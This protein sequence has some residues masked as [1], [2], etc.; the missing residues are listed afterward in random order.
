MK[1]TRRGTVSFA[2]ASAVALATASAVA[3]ATAASSGCARTPVDSSWLFVVASDTVTVEEAAAHWDSFSPGELR[4]FED[5]QDL[6]RDFVDAYSGM[7]LVRY[8]LAR[9]GF[10][11]TPEFAMQREGTARIRM[12]NALQDSVLSSR[13]RSVSDE[14]IASFLADSGDFFGLTDSST[15]HASAR[16]RIGQSHAFAELDSLLTTIRE[17][18]PAEFRPP[19]IARFS[20]HFRGEAELEPGDTLITGPAGTWTAGRMLGELEFEASMHEVLPADSNW[21]A[22]YSRLIVNRSILAAEFVRR[23]PSEADDLMGLATERAVETAAES[24]YRECV[25]DRVVVTDAM[26]DSVYQA[27]PP[28]VEEKRSM[29]AL[30]V[31]Y[32][33]IEEFEAA[34][35]AGTIESVVPAFENCY[36]EEIGVSPPMR[37]DQV[38]CGLGDSLFAL[39]DTV[40]WI[41]PVPAGMDGDSVLIAARLAEVFPARIASREE[42]A[43]VITAEIRGRLAEARIEEWLAEIA[44]SAGFAVNEPLLSSL[45]DDPG[46]WSDLCP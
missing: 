43:P 17:S 36:P 19:A 32:D 18:S 40:S 2:T 45:P 1:S 22:D 16:T 23:Y 4:V 35:A 26:I 5:S 3:L 46:A 12:M 21:M 39:S 9:R 25:L 13:T 34:R 24:L 7:F 27:S 10:L 31:P 28:P 30:M 6:K 42:V 11:D 8:E 41:G 44:D 37:R 29:V 20:A 15:A 38:P 33:R 14:E